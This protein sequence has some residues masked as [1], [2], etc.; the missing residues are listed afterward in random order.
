MSESQTNEELY[1]HWIAT[2]ETVAKSAGGTLARLS[3]LEEMR[4]YIEA[5]ERAYVIKARAEGLSWSDI[6]GQ[7]GMSKQAAQKKFGA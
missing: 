2:S 1:N 5:T 3:Q 6:G 4:H 7:F